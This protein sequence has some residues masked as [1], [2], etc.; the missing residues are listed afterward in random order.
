MRRQVSCKTLALL[1]LGTSMN[2]GAAAG[3]ITAGVHADWGSDTDFGVGAR[4]V[5]SLDGLVPNLETV[6]SFDYFFPGDD[7]GADVT[8]WE[9]N[10][11][12]VYRF[13]TKGSP[14][15]PYA[16]A[17]LNFAYLK[18]SADV[19]DIEVSGDE[20]RGGFNLLGGL[21]FDIGRVKPFVEGRVESGGGEQF[22]VSAGV[23]F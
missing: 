23:R 8:Y 18:A 20:S 17:G 2:A 16:G 15:K 12:V 1:V 21:L 13:N 22:V 19:L 5:L 14:I 7:V 4:A 11:N 3:Q 6:G 9:V 10:A